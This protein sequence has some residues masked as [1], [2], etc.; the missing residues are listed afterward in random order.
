[1]NAPFKH[2]PKTYPEVIVGGLRTACV[3]R[4]QLAQLMVRECYEARASGVS[5][6]LVF[7]VNGQAISLATSDPELRR[8]YDLADHVHAD[9][10]PLVFASC[11]LA[12]PGIPERSPVTDFFH[13]AALAARETGLRF[14]LLG[15]TEAD[16]AACADFMR[17][18][19]PGLAIAGRRN[20][21]FQP[22]E[23][24]SICS[25]INAAEADVVWV[26]LGIPL[27]QAFCVRNRHRIRAGWLIA[28]GGC[29]NYVSGRYRRAPLWMQRAGLE[30]LYRLWREPRRLFLRYA[31]TNP[32]AL[33]LL[34]TRTS[35]VASSHTLWEGRC[36]EAARA[37]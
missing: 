36:T 20:G 35:S 34:L 32:H 12:P 2:P 24:E 11:L 7:H 19:Y 1:M 4:A 23:E 27:Q 5:P 21:Y 16:N 17:R 8:L 18:N 13:D 37:R 6:K 33:Y 3:S 28:A 14:Y 9:G 15:S 26:G 25:E 31:V 10:Q 29:F 30:W 22:G